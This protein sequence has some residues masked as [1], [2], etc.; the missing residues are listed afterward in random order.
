[1]TTVASPDVLAAS[2][3]SP[4]GALI[5]GGMKKQPPPRPSDV[6]L[7]RYE[8]VTDIDESESENESDNDSENESENESESESDN[9]SENGAAIGLG[10]ASSVVIGTVLGI[11]A[12]VLSWTSNGQA[13]W[14]YGWRAF[15]STCAFIFSIPYIVSHVLHKSDLLRRIAH[16]ENGLVWSA[17]RAAEVISSNR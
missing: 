9:D 15:F 1:M 7:E 8:D 16:V 13:K 5:L 2:V 17:S 11:V 4:L 12:A 14:D 6:T 10:V 3:I